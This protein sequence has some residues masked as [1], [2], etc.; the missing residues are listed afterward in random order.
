MAIYLLTVYE[1]VKRI[2][3]MEAGSEDDA[4]NWRGKELEVEEVWS[5]I[6]EIESIEQED[7]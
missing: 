7:N 6:D 4:A 1:Q 5:H 2:Y 3:H